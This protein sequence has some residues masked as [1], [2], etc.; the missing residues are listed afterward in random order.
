MRGEFIVK[1]EVSANQEKI[2]EKL[3]MNK[4]VIGCI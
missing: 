3:C 2:Y 4:Y 1:W